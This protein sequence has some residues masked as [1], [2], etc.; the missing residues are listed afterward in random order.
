MAV[1]PKPT[2][3]SRGAVLF[4][5]ASAIVPGGGVASVRYNRALERTLYV[6]RGDGARIWDVDCNEYLDLCMSHGASLLGHNHPGVRERVTQALEMGILCSYE[7][8]H[9][10]AL[11]RKMCEMVPGA[12]MVRFS[13]SGTETVM[14]ALR[15]ARACTGKNKLIKFEG[16]FHGYSDGVFWSSAPPLDEAGPAHSPVPYRQSSGIPDSLGGDI[17]VVPFNDPSALERALSEHRDEVAA[18]IMEPVNYDAGCI[19]PRPGFLQ[20][21]RELTADADVLLIFDEVLTAFRIAPGGAQEY[22]GVIPDLS[23]LGKATGGGL[24]LSAIAG[25]R[26]VMSHLRPL[27]D[28]EHSGTYMGHLFSVMGGLAALEALSEPGVHERLFRLGDRLYDGIR[29]LIAETGI[30]ARLQHLGPRFFVYFGLDPAE[31]VWDYRTAAGHSRDMALAFS[32]ETMARGVYFHDY[33][34]GL[35]HHGFSTAHTEQDVDVALA[36]IQGAFRAMA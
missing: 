12:E 1:D 36:A 28:A 18:L 4:E 5:E 24:P 29:R 21:V 35:A 16:H 19:L 33:G 26:E 17:I 3:T 34:G 7:T 20:T 15:L 25:K 11:A 6:S 32:R 27:G 8:E 30:R 10:V 13:G 23:V 9:H 31:E 14:H 22:Y 2:Q